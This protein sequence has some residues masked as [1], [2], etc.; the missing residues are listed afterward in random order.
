[1]KRIYEALEAL[2]ELELN[3]VPDSLENE[4]DWDVI[5][6]AIYELQDL[7]AIYEGSKKPSPA[8]FERNGGYGLSAEER[9]E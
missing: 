5:T 8:E 9:N 6:A 1:M 3:G 7:T 4:I 2:N